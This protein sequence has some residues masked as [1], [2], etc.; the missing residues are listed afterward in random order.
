LAAVA[1]AVAGCWWDEALAVVLE[2]SAGGVRGWVDGAAVC[3][4]FGEAIFSFFG[5]FVVVVRDECKT[6]SPKGCCGWL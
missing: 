5:V 1:V 3:D 6:D 2:G 4:W